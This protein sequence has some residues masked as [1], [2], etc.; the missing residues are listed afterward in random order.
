MVKR[1][2]GYIFNIG[3][4]AGKYVYERGNIYCATKF[5]V[6][7]ISEAMRIDL[8]KNNIR[9]TQILPGLAETEFS[10]VRFK[11]DA[12]RAKQ[13]YVGIKALEAYD[14]AELVRY[15]LSLPS[16]VCI[17]ELVVTPAAQANPFYINKQA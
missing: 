5:A 16:H 2:T 14:I 12:E 8:L 1:N 15:C 6:D 4:V 13:T 11:G 7:A 9:I 10:L 3:S 17:N